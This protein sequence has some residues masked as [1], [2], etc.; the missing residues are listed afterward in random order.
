VCEVV[1]GI[2][3]LD[4][5]SQFEGPA[6][7]PVVIKLMFCVHRR[8]D[9]SAE[10]FHRYWRDVHGPL[11]QTVASVLGIRKYVQAHTATGPVGE[12]LAASR[13]APESYDGVAELWFDSVAALIE[14]SAS[15]EGVAAGD[16]LL[17][18]EKRFIDHARSPLFLVEEH[19]VL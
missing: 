8:A 18:D 12:A 14:A 3:H 10:E 7:A 16:T 6:Y 5:V 17:A 1:A 2:A 19:A 13:G 4:N 15:P 11:V 9:M